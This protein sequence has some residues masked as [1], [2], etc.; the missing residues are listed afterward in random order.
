MKNVSKIIH[1]NRQI[2][3]SNRKHGTNEPPLIVR[4]AKGKKRFGN[5]HELIIEGPCKIVYSPH[6]PLDCGARL[7]IETD[8][9]VTGII[10]V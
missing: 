6:K 5:A 4:A 3:D 9:E 1:V 10:N 2:I 7:W 8:S